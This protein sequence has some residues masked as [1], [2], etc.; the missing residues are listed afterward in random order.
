[1]AKYACLKLTGRGVASSFS[2]GP[3]D[4]HLRALP[5]FPVVPTPY[6]SLDSFF[7]GASGA[8]LGVEVANLSPS[9]ARGSSWLVPT[10][11]LLSPPGLG[12]TVLTTRMNSLLT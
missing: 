9:C 4:G 11:L 5:V 3:R 12:A 10:Y 1:M 7:P 6:L 2:V 8:R